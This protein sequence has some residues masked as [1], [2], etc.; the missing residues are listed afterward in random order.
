[1]LADELNSAGF[2]MRKTLKEQVEIPWEPHTAKEF[3]WRPIMEM[4][5]GIDSTKE[6]TTT[7]IDKVYNTLN[8]HLS[9]KFGVHV[10][11]PSEEQMAYEEKKISK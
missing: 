9:T 4:Q 10:P 8:L 5:L 11:W 2:D 7:D 1:M 6:L 3:L